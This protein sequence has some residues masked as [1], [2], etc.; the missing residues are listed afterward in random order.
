M[1]NR[2][3]SHQP[4]N[5]ILHHGYTTCINDPNDAEDNDN[6]AKMYGCRGEHRDKPSYDTEQAHFYHDATEHH[7]YRC[8]GLIVSIR[9]PGMKREDRHL[10]GKGDK[11]QPEK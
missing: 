6:V 1:G 5:V 9:L 8:R 10:N 11:K 2:R 7:C 4:L 3:I